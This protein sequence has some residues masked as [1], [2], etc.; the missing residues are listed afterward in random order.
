MIVLDLDEN[1][2]LMC[3]GHVCGLCVRECQDV[4]FIYH[5][6]EYLN[7]IALNLMR[8]CVL[9]YGGYGKLISTC[10]APENCCAPQKREKRSFD[11]LKRIIWALTAQFHNNNPNS[12]P[13]E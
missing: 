5:F 7:T 3:P 9:N 6:D 11:F 4:A 1:G 2:N 10:T 12:A 13:T 8:F